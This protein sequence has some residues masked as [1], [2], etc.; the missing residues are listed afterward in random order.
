MSEYEVRDP[1]APLL[2]AGI[3]DVG[4]QVELLR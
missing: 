3:T 4:G 1:V 2:A